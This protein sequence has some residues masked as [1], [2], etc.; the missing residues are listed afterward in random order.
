MH[1]YYGFHDRIKNFTPEE[2][3]M[4]LKFRIKF[5][6]EELQETKDASLLAQYAAE[7]VVDGII[8]LMVVSIGTLD[9]F[10]VDIYKA[11]NRVY[12]ANMSKKVGIKESRPNPLGLPDLI[13]PETWQAPT[14]S[15]NLGHLSKI[16][17]KM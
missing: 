1:H 8:D 2:W 10:G 16:Q 17:K 7:E 4:L 12:V 15:D 11:W 9:L 13:K 3:V 14:H 6:E 5:L